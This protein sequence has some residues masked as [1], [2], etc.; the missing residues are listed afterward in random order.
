MKFELNN[1]VKI[2]AVGLGTW[3]SSSDDAYQATLYALEAGYRHIDT[4]MI[5]RNEADVGRAI[6][7]SNISRKEV[8]IT[9]KVWNSDQGYEETIEACNESLKDLDMA[10][11]K[12][13]GKIPVTISDIPNNIMTAVQ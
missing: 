10:I 7:N 13:G 3:K 2:P 11:K 6:R 8:F 4:A 1:G 9:S 12:S 5:Y